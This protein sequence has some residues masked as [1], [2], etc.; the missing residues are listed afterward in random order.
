VLLMR[1]PGTRDRW[2]PSAFPPPLAADL[3]V[4]RVSAGLLEPNIRW[5]SLLGLLIGL[6]AGSA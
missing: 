4:S 1:C 5:H 6:S 3:T 2:I